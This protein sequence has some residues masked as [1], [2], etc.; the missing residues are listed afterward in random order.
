MKSNEL[1]K[2]AEEIIN[3]YTNKLKS[4][5]QM[6]IEYGCKRYQIYYLLE[7]YGIN[8]RSNTEANRRYQINETYFDKIDAPEKA[9]IL[10]FLFADGYNNTITNSI[11]L[12]LNIDD[13]QILEEI[14][15]LCGSDKPLYFYEYTHKDGQIRRYANMTLCSKHMCESLKQYGMVANKS[16]ILDFPIGIPEKL[17]SH[18]YRGYLDGDGCI[19]HYTNLRYNNR[20]LVQL[21]SSKQFCQKSVE[22][23]NNKLN[24]H[25]YLTHDK[26]HSDNTWNLRMSS[27]HDVKIF[28]DWIYQDSTIKLQRKYDIY[29][30]YIK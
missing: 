28:L 8:T 13:Y 5:N 26:C 25:T 30:M 23:L 17:M 12:T 3:N 20:N 21:T 29:N 24:I 2:Y 22:Y 1:Q 18:F 19:H 14:K 6:S 9:Y 15:T 10:G 27:K 7:K 4:I 16:L 11:V